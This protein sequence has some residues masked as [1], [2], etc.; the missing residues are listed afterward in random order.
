MSDLSSFDT[1]DLVTEL[2]K[3]SAHGV[4][5]CTPK[6]AARLDVW[7]GDRAKCLGMTARLSYGINT[8]MDE[9]EDV[10]EESEEDEAESG[11]DE[12]AKEFPQMGQYL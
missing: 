6:G 1:Q 4:I 5:S 12:L 3:R 7:W 2:G 11:L 9:Y 8:E 10:G